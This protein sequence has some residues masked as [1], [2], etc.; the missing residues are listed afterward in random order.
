MVGDGVR[1]RA[2]T[3]SFC[4]CALDPAR[5]CLRKKIEKV[6]SKTNRTTTNKTSSLQRERG[7][8]RETAKE[9]NKPV[10]EFVGDRCAFELSGIG[11]TS[12]CP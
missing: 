3:G 11:G 4:K 2:A 12:P 6:S 1:G 7:R 9:R 5:G 8:E 10:P